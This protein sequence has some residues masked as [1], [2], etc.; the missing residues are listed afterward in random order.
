MSLDLTALTAYTDE[1]KMD[2]IRA[3][4]LKGKTL[5]LISVQADIKSSA[6]I[7]ILSSTGVWQAGACGWNPQGSTILSQRNLAVADIKKN[8]AICLNDLEAFYME[9]FFDMIG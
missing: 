1:N 6:A 8:E 4:I 2:L 9:R 5:S 7:N 3:S